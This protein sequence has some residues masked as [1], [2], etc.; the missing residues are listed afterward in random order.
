[1]AARIFLRNGTFS[2]AVSSYYRKRCIQRDWEGNMRIGITLKII[3][4]T[5]VVLAFMSAT[6]FAYVGKPVAESEVSIETSQE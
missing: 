4:I 1:M 5:L 6:A 3:T 2:G